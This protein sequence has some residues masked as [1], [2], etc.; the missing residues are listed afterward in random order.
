MIVPT[1]KSSI[2]RGDN[3]VKALRAQKDAELKT[4]NR[5]MAF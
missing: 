2:C 4:Q 1:E 3:P 5:K